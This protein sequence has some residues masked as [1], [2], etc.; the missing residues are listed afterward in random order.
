MGNAAGKTVVGLD[1]EPGY[2]VAVE[3]RAGGRPAIEHAATVSLASGVVTEGEVA[4][5]DTLAAALRELFADK[6]LG[7]RVRIGVANQRIVMRTL[8]LPPM[9]AKDIDS[10]VRFQ[11]QEHIPMPL[12]QAVL[13]HHSLGIV[14]TP[15]GPRTRV[16]LV[17]ARRDMIDAVL[18]AV[19]KAG[20]RAEGIDLAAFAM[21]RALYRPDL[22]GTTLYLSM[23]G[24]TNIAVAVGTTCVFTR[25]VAYGTET[26]VTEL[27]ERR[28]LT[29]EHAQGWLRHVGLLVPTDDIEGD[30]DIVLEARA[31]AS[32]GLRRVADEIRNSLDFFRTQHENSDVERAVLTGPA[33]AIPGVADHLG[34]EIG[35]PIE[36]GVAEESKPGALA[37]VEPARAVV[38][39]GLAVAEVAA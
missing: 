13:E 28:G 25:A 15:D 8:H 2:V 30:R 16:V 38:A 17:A 14:Q 5:V 32:D 18:G 24:I 37:G 29:S 23:G 35:L 21:I 34:A 39:A 9:D 36:V 19:H 3:A 10:A 6:K 12:E 26:M 22:S 1:I 31:V 20:L 4:D 7:R 33:A 27:A 11:A